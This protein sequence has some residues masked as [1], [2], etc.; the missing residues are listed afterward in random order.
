M[1]DQDENRR[2]APLSFADVLRL[3]VVELEDVAQA[4]VAMQ[5]SISNL[6]AQA[7]HPDLGEEIHMLQD[8]DRLQQ[9]VVEIAAVIRTTSESPNPLAVSRAAIG[10]AIRLESFRNRIGLGTDSEADRSRQDTPHER[11]RGEIT[12]L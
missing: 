6:L 3:M 5:T 2:E 1:Q 11:A 12:W 8:I 10:S 7:H 4:C 9:T